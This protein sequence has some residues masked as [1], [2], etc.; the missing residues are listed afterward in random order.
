M[1]KQ[2]LT[3]KSMLQGRFFLKIYTSAKGLVMHTWCNYDP[4][5]SINKTGRGKNTNLLCLHKQC[6][7]LSSGKQ[8]T[9]QGKQNLVDASRDSNTRGTSLHNKVWRMLVMHNTWL[10]G[11]RQDM[12][13]KLSG[14]EENKRN[15]NI[16]FN[17]PSK[18]WEVFSRHHQ[19]TTNQKSYC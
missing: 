2:Q 11:W 12:K 16:L 18:N 19:H 8:W 10:T 3:L 13:T 1:Q 5:D 17:Q 14:D 4:L 6:Q 7:H 9:A 15:I